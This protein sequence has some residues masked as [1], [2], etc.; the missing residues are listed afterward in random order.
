MNIALLGYGK[1]GKT[2]EAVV[3]EENEGD[4][5]VLKVDVDNMNDL[6][7]E[8]LSKADVAIEFSTP[9]SA[10]D[11]IMKCFEANVP[12][13]CGTT[14]WTDRLDEV[15]Q[16]CEKQQKAFFYASNFSIGVNMFFELN[17]QLARLMKSQPQYEVAIHEVHHTEKLDKPSGTAITLANDLLEQMDRKTKWVN[18][19]SENETNLSV[20]SYREEDVP[21][22]HIINYESE[23]DGIE[24]KHTAHSRKGFATGAVHAAAWLVGKQGFFRMKDM[25]RLED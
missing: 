2:I 9:K 5:I 14:G 12:V 20:I 17:R 13:V 24:I 18:S 15:R 1:M 21:G 4:E 19:S 6:T 22:I 23:F 10:Y 7:I 16:I 3:N 8:Q 11:N 25:L